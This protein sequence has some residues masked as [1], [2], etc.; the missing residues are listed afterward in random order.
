MPADL[1]VYALVAA[2]LVFWLRSVLG[3]RHGEERDR[4]APFL[5]GEEP[6]DIPERTSSSEEQT[7]SAADQIAALA[8]TPRKNY[9]VDNKTAESG[10]ITIA[11]A[12]RDFDVEQFLEG[13]QDAFVM[14]VESFAEGDRD[15]LKELLAEDVYNAFEGA[16]TEREERKETQITE[17][18]AIR[19]A[20]VV[21]AEL[22]QGRSAKITVKFTAE[23]SSVTRDKDDKIIAGHPDKTSTMH[24]IWT[25]GRDVKSK[26]PS[27]LLMETR[28][29]FEDDN[30]LIPDSVK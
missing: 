30:D 29:D 8:A 13:A 14:I 12:D 28:G 16:I 4:A 27:W 15:T 21:F 24:D 26:D 2:G 22:Q 20:N 10:L 17:I 9:A 5:S 3:T 25:F 19:K 6:H 1:I 23:E 18:H 7:S 11:E